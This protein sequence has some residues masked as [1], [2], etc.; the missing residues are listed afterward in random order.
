MKSY[1][2]LYYRIPFSETDAMAIVHHSNHARYLERGRIELLRLCGLEYS[3]LMNRGM[4][5]PVLELQTSF[6][7]PLK[8]DEVILIETTIAEASRTRLAFSYKIFTVPELEKPS[9]SQEEFVGTPSVM[10]M[11]SHCCVN[12]EG[13]PIPAQPDVL[14]RLTE[15]QGAGS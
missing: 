1:C 13:R 6:K 8:F 4:Q 9:L 15:L 12:S 14:A 10:G 7:K 2:R 11:T 3:N 5:Y